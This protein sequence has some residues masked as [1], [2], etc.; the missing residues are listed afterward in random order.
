VKSEEFEN[1][2]EL[3]KA[4]HIKQLGFGKT[5]GWKASTT[6]MKLG[7]KRPWTADEYERG[8]HLV[9]SHGISIDRKTMLRF[10]TPADA[11]SDEIGEQCNE[12]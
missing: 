2:G 5:M 11:A 6:Y 3:L 4:K 1:L 8:I 10:A 7:R 9:R 12:A